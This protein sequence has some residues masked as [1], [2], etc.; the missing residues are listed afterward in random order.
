MLEKTSPGPPDD[1]RVTNNREILLDTAL[2]SL[3]LS[4]SLSLERV[5]E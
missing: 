4:L 3:S 5:K 1:R 2:F